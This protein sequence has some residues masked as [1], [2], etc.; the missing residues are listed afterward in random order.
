[1]VKG[2]AYL[3]AT[4]F[5]D[6]L[7]YSC[8]FKLCDSVEMGKNQFDYH[9]HTI[10]NCGMLSKKIFYLLFLSLNVAYS[11][12]ASD[13][14]IVRKLLDST[15]AFYTERLGENTLLYN[16]R[17][18]TGSYSRSI[19]YPFYASD[20]PQKGSIVYDG[21]LYSHPAISYDL[22]ND[23]VIIKTIQNKSIKLLNEKIDQFSLGDHVF[24]HIKQQT[25]GVKGLDPGFYEVLL[26][27]KIKVLAKRK[28]QLTPS[29]NLEDPY[30]FV[31]YDK[32]FLKTGGSFQE[33]TS[34][35][36][37]L[38]SFPSQRKEI[39]KYMRKKGI[40]FKINPEYAVL[41]VAEYLGGL[42]N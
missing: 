5:F 29:F 31:H 40:S 3:L 9:Q 36:S 11:Q 26:N 41:G 16:G 34:D 4:C 33:I 7:F 13:T 39:K 30:R 35:G 37:L 24:V 32:F 22:V 21:I 28:K 42:K 19:G 12:N 6:A 23:E 18:Y 25:P 14:L 20:Q 15:V 38:A 8:K 1:M 2:G 27:D 17:E 10:I